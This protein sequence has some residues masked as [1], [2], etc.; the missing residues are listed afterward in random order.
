MKG[1]H[2]VL[3]GRVIQKKKQFYTAYPLPRRRN[4]AA[5]V[6]IQGLVP[7]TRLTPVF[8]CSSAREIT[9]LWK[10]C[11]TSRLCVGYKHVESYRLPLSLNGFLKNHKK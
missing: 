2:Y 3:Q 5:Y 8:W 4:C 1:S 6:P 10:M 9:K 7:F 11:I